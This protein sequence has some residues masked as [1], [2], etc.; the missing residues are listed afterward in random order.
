MRRHA[1][2]S[3]VASVVAV[4]AISYAT[5]AAQIDMSRMTCKSLLQALPSDPGG[6]NLMWMSG[7]LAGRAGVTI[8]GR[9]AGRRMISARLGPAVRYE[10]GPASK[11]TS[12]TSS[13]AR[14]RCLLRFSKG[15]G[16][17]LIGPQLCTICDGGTFG[18]TGYSLLALA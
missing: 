10:L 14:R 17:A 3:V 13:E 15:S 5:Q 11:L 2:A 6:A 12:S 16:S 8:F 18:L 1:L 4:V 9:T 7:Y